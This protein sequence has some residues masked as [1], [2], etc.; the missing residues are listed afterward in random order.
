M[1]TK[2]NYV[3]TFFYEVELITIVINGKRTLNIEL[4]AVINPFSALSEYDHRS[5]NNN[6]HVSVSELSFSLFCRPRCDGKEW[7]VLFKGKSISP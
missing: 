2:N 1:K 7:L 5:L 6:N 3:R 4:G